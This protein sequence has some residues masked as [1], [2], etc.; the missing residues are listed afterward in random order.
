MMYKLCFEDL[1]K[2]LRDIMRVDNSSSSIFEGKFIILV[3]TSDKIYLL[4]L[5]EM[6]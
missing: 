2:I 3:E 1:D 5:E 6:F 4:F